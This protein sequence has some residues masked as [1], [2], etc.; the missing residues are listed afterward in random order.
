MNRPSAMQE[1][2]RPEAAA[3]TFT[4][5]SV[6]DVANSSVGLVQ[7]W[8]VLLEREAALAR[9][10]LIWLIV[11]TLVLPVFIVGIWIGIS[12]ACASLVQHLTGDWASAIV[13]TTALQ[14]IA[15]ATLLSKIRRW[16]RDLSF[17]QSRA[18]LIRIMEP[19]P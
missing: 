7:A 12:A 15:L 3:D 19:K 6:E 10:S 18:A 8:L 5:S 2:T 11:G 16:W 13:I 17:P 4:Q 1:P 9:H 14:F